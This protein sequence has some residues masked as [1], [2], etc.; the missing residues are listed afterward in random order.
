VRGIRWLTALSA[1]RRGD[2]RTVRS[3]AVYIALRRLGWPVVF[4]TG[5]D[6]ERPGA[7]ERSWVELDDHLLW[8]LRDPQA[9]ATHQEIF[10]HPASAPRADGGE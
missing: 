9:R 6:R 2:A 1:G 7:L 5:V 3:L 4:V 10:R 8:E